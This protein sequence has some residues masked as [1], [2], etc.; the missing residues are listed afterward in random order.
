MISQLIFINIFS[1]FTA[2]LLDILIGDPD[3]RFHPVRIIGRVVSSLEEKYYPLSDKTNGGFKLMTYTL[4][5]TAV[6]VYIVLT[7]SYMIHPYIYFALNTLVIFFCISVRSMC[8][9]ALRV[10]EPLSKGDI[11]SARKSLSMIVSRDTDSMDTEG[12]VRSTV[13]SVSENF[14]DGVVSPVLYGVLLGGAGA[15]FFKAVSTL[16]S[17]VGYKNEKYKD[18]GKPS[19]LLD[20]ALN[21][22][23]SRL[24]VGII[25][26]GGMSMGK[27]AGDIY[28]SV[29]EYRLAHPS[30]NS[31]H[32]M[33]AF[34]GALD[35]TLGG[36]VKYFGSMKDKPY[37]GSGR[38]SLTPDVIQEAVNLFRR[39]AFAGVLLF[40][41][42][43]LAESFLI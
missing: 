21:F 9:H 20:D 6:P 4:V 22:L 25:M 31:A 40:T 35:V 18:F 5:Y 17:M 36:P 1:V 14:T 33:S 19:A 38:R 11:D 29:S 34:A 42:L 16:D 28:E 32:S 23:P 39:S 3:F 26:M 8:E 13:E 30:P 15:F 43:P 24:S 10:L 27:S 7:V 41:A 37:I 12:I 2:Y